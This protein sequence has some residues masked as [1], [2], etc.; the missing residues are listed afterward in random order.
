MVRTVRSS[1]WIEPALGIN[2]KGACGRHLFAGREPLH[3]SKT[4][5][6]A[7]TENDSAPLINSRLDFDIDDFAR[8]GIDN[9]RLGYAQNLIVRRSGQMDEIAS[10]FSL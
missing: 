10:G 1:A 7:R 4:I 3:Y 5:A 8:S 6:R 2:Q 9:R